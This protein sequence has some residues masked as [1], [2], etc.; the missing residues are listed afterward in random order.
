MI[1][2][3]LHKRPAALDRQK[4]RNFKLDR[5][6]RDM[7]RSKGL[8]AFFIAAGEFA[9]ACKDYPIVWVPAGQDAKGKPQ[10]ASIAV[11]G[12]Q[13]GQNLCIDAA[14]RWRVRYVPAML[15]TYPFAMARTSETE[16]MLC[17]DEDWVG[18]SET[19]GEPLFKADGS[20][21]ELTL[22]VQQQLEQLEID[23]ERTRRY[24][25][26]LVELGLWRQA[27]RAVRR[28]DAGH[29][30]HRPARP[31][32]RAPDLAVEHVPPGRVASRARSGPADA[33]ARRRQRRALRLIPAPAD[34]GT[35]NARPAR[36]LA[37]VAHWGH[38]GLR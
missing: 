26:K 6:A 25:E 13:Q 14:D 19:N 17:V 38:A 2:E 3:N 27:E 7:A 5:N 36:S 24:G 12:L 8:N 18:L 9:E 20:P 33:G 31:D 37:G 21:T 32:P 16:M 30:A 34:A 1:N 11:F 35:R 15:R 4:H 29:G 23:I 10:V 28:A 22:G